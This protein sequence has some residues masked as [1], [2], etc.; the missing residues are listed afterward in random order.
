MRFILIDRITRW[1]AGKTATA[2]K[3]VALSEDFFDDHFPNKPILPGVLMLEG[4][5]QLS[6]LLLEEAVFEQY[7]Q[8][9]KALLSQVA[10]AKFRSPVYPGDRLA[11]TAEIVSINELGGKTSVRAGR[12]RLSSPTDTRAS[13]EPRRVISRTFWPSRSP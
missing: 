4:M 11:Y 12:T 3:N 1:E 8:R 2:V 9:L 10:K 6:G 13:Y 7:D 5:A